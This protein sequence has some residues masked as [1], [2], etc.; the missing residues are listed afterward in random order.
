MVQSSTGLYA[1]ECEIAACS[2]C[3]IEDYTMANA[4]REMEFITVFIR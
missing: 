4:N 3:K 1:G 2:T